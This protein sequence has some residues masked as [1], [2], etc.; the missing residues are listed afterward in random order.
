MRLKLIR[1]SGELWIDG[2]FFCYVSGEIYP[3]EYE[4]KLTMSEMLQR[5]TPEIFTSSGNIRML[6]EKSEYCKYLTLGK[7]RRGMEL[8]ETKTAISELMNKVRFDKIT[9]EVTN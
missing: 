6:S 1:K 9:L 3:G 5:V 4:V 8:F 2:V 7:H